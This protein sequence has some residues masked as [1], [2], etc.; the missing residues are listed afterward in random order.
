M[1]LLSHLLDYIQTHCVFF[2]EPG[3]GQPSTKS[4]LSHAPD[5][6]LNVSFHD[7][8]IPKQASQGILYLK[9]CLHFCLD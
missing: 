6:N 3:T 2:I 8:Q 7:H 4:V 5:P 1:Y 9:A